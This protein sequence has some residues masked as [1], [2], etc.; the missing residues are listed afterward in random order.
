[1]KN[2]ISQRG[3]MDAVRTGWPSRTHFLLLLFVLSAIARYCSTGP[4]VVPNT[5]DL[6]S[7]H[8]RW[9]TRTP[10]IGGC[11]WSWWAP[12]GL[13]FIVE[14]VLSG[15][16]KEARHD[17][18]LRKLDVIRA[19]RSV[20]SDLLTWSMHSTMPNTSWYELR[21]KIQL[22]VLYSCNKVAEICSTLI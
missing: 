8:R 11:P 16:I 9:F 3:S 20:R 5:L 21:I 1:M 18:I 22:P 12:I 19:D 10:I 4:F 14:A 6:C 13:L 2:A 15:I 7:R 17:K